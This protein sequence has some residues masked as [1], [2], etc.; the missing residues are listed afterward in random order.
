S[1][2]ASTLTDAPEPTEPPTPYVAS[3]ARQ[4]I[5]TPLDRLSSFKADQGSLRTSLHLKFEPERKRA[6]VAVLVRDSGRVVAELGGIEVEQQPDQWLCMRLPPS[7][8]W[9]LI[10]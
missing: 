3:L 8:R 9:K 5:V 7:E 6:T 2:L 10:L 1:A 4:K